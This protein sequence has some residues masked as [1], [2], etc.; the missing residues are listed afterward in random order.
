MDRTLAGVR[1]RV[2]GM[3]APVSPQPYPER[4]LGPDPP[5]LGSSLR[6]RWLRRARLREAGR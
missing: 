2:R 1:A 5:S 4:A 3:R 6:K